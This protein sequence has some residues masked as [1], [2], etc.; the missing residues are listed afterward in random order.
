MPGGELPELIA[1]FLCPFHNALSALRAV[2]PAQ[3][4]P[5]LPELLPPH[6]RAAQRVV[7]V[8]GTSVFVDDAE[9]LVEFVDAV[10]H[11]LLLALEDV[12]DDLGRSGV[13]FEILGLCQEG[14]IVA[15]KCPQLDIFQFS[16]PLLLILLQIFLI[17]TVGR[18]C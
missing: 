17:P 10:A 16:S 2:L 5:A 9:C 11:V 8:V 12:A 7:G 3:L 18:F 1:R 14:S 13:H 4:E 15:L 6:L